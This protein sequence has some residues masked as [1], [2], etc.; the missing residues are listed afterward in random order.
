[1]MMKIEELS[2][3]PKVNYAIIVIGDFME[4]W[5]SIT[6]YSNYEI[7]NYGRLRK[8]DKIIKPTHCTNGY[9]EYALWKKGIRKVLLAHRLVAYYFLSNPNN[10]PEINHLDEDITNNNVSNLEWCSSKYNANY[11]TRNM[12]CKNANRHN[13]KSVSQFDLDGNFIKEYE[14]ISD[15]AREVNGDTSFISRACRGLSYT[16]YGYKWKFN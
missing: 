5:K 9:L 8:G 14:C 3:K 7:S 11:G 12:K 10:L 2:W 15:A 13:F 6:D 1:M 4:T 16:A